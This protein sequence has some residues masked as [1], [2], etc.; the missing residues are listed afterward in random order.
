[1]NTDQIIYLSSVNR[2]HSL[3]KASEDLHITAQALSQSL[4]SLEKE[5]NLKLTESSRKG[6]FLTVNGRILLEAGEDF[7]RTIAELQNQSI[8]NSYKHLPNAKLSI[9]V[10][11]GISNTLLPK[12]L[13]K[14][15]L[16]VPNIL[17]NQ[18]Q[19]NSTSE[20]LNIISQSSE[21]EIAF[22]SIFKYKNGTLPNLQEYSKLEFQPII[23]AK[24][25]C[26]V[27]PSHEI[28]HYNSV[29]IAT[30]LK[31][32]IILSSS[33]ED[34]MLQLLKSYAEPKKILSVP[35][36][37]TYT[38]IVNTSPYLAFNRLFSSYDSSF[39]TN[40]RKLILLKEDI[41]VSFGYV[42]RKGHK[43]SSAMQEFLTV[44]SEYLTTEYG[45]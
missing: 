36:F 32:P 28:Y 27:P 29:S 12:A 21:Y 33:G 45:S 26:S 15:Y 5:L 30:V 24:Y 3:H 40:G 10:T 1:M 37:A 13:S 18:K 11:E 19:L 4:S 35:D 17:I 6:T 23:T 43:F 16:N 31:Y 34:I 38:S 20:L 41:T 9:L 14:I 25:C 44:V 39:P 7:L 2:Y 22:A 8:Q 42:Y